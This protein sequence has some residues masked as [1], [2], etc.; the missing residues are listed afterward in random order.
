MAKELTREGPEARGEPGA[1][2]QRASATDD[3]LVLPLDERL[4]L[5]DVRCRRVVW[6][7]QR[8]NGRLKL[9]TA[10]G[11]DHGDPLRAQEML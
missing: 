9:T 2:Q 11:V 5:V 6:H 7:S 10:V 8:T 3:G 1:L 4:A